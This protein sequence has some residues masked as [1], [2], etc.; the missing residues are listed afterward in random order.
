R[1]Y[2]RFLKRRLGAEVLMD[3]V[4]DFTAVGDTFGGM[5]GGARAVQTWNVKLSSD[6]L[7]A[8]GRPNASEECPCERDRKSSVVQALHLMNSNALQGKLKDAKGR[9]AMLA[10][11]VPAN[12]DA[13][14]E[15]YLA[16]YCR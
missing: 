12:A 9:A 14:K 15:L 3:A 16:A 6:F 7:D 8:F 13:V 2:S 10:K 4:N 1:N 11:N 5:P